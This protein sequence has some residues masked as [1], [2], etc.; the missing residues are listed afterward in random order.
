M[1]DGDWT[2]EGDAV[3]L[4]GSVS[5][6]EFKTIL[7]KTFGAGKWA[8]TSAY[9][10]KAQED[11]LRR[12][13]AGT[14]PKGQVSTH[15]E[16]DEEDPGAF[17]FVVTGMSQKDAAKKLAA[18]DGRFSHVFA[19]ASHGPQGQH[20]HASTKLEPAG[21]EWTAVGEATPI[22]A[23]DTFNYKDAPRVSAAPRP[24]FLASVK[25][26]TAA[27]THPALED[28]R[29]INR[30]GILGG[31]NPINALKA[32]G[33]IYDVATSPFAALAEQATPYARDDPRRHA[34]GALAAGL[35]PIG[36]PEKVAEGAAL[37]TAT[38]A[39]ALGKGAISAAQRAV[40]KARMAAPAARHA[41]KVERLEAEGVQLTPGMR[42]GG[43]ARTAE[44]AK[45]SSPYVGP[46]IEDA[47]RGA[48]ESV[49][50][51]VYNRALKP[52]GET[53]QGPVGR[54]GVGQ[55]QDRFSAAYESVLPHVTAKAD[56]EFSEGLAGLSEKVK[57][58]GPD[59]QARFHAIVSQD[60]AHY[61]TAGGGAIDGRTFKNIESEL[62]RQARG[63]KGDPSN[64]ERSL[65]H[66]VDD[67]NDLLRD[68]AERSS[69]P[70]VRQ[71]LK[72]INTGYAMFTRIQDAA[73]RRVGA[74][75]GVFNTGD[76]MAAVKKG[77]RS[78]RKGSFARGDALLQD[79]AEDAHAVVRAKLPDS[80][81]AR[82]VKQGLAG[83]VLGGA[84]GAA[85]GSHAGLV[86]EMAGGAVGSALGGAIDRPIAA[87]TNQ[88]ARAMLARSASRAPKNYL[89]RVG[90]ATSPLVTHRQLGA[91][92]GGVNALRA[93]TQTP[94]QQP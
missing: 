79:F 21:G 36:G 44:E 10:T 14:V 85:V 87:T 62:S 57:K 33:D 22:K 54:Q 64:K 40:E 4:K 92:A 34:A 3:P 80:G 94:Q 50:R 47:E 49:N 18:A 69:P 90:R 29:A 84:M 56:T 63:M 16:G 12:G 70:G 82:R 20:V 83:R 72:D 37:K 73:A 38:K 59:E 2:P 15:S 68:S 43:E 81:T 9:R 46:A 1:A 6:A 8:P 35:L 7:N 88:L 65:G 11:A 27:Y 78:V 19:E 61:F 75:D 24:N 39:E 52:L 23:K 25:G 42:K 48:I 76:L 45:K 13:G 28:L 30:Q 41:A 74:E 58:L 32:A 55:L 89:A 17:D 5:K 31:L 77:D 91:G 71:K 67:L 86:G 53:Y 26:D 93:V 60:V 66:L 51:A